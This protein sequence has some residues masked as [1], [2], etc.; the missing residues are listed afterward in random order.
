MRVRRRDVIGGS[1]GFFAARVVESKATLGQHATPTSDALPEATAPFG[2]S[3]MDLPGSRANISAHFSRLPRT[4]HG[5]SRNPITPAGPDRLRVSYGPEDSTLGAPLVIQAI[6][7]REGDFFPVD[8]TPGKYIAT[9]AGTDDSGAISFGQD[10]G[11]AWIQAETFAAAEGGDAPG[12][13]VAMRPLHTLAWGAIA[14]SWLFT[15]AAITPEG[16]AAL[17]AAFTAAADPSRK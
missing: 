7:F 13:P 12:T 8:F 2:L 3:G 17:V 5:L 6:D 10:H 11:I 15:T 14:G 16:L 9:A 4:V 1:A